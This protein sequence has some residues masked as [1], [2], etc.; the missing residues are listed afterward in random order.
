MEELTTA[1]DL[2]SR[3]AIALQEKVDILTE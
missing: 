1:L 3:E 2:K